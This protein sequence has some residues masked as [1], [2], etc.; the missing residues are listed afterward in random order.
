MEGKKPYMAYRSGE[1]SMSIKD[2][3]TCVD[4]QPLADLRPESK[5]DM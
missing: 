2:T 1:D 3:N 5:R 4:G